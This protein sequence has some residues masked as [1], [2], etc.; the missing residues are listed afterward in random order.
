[1]TRTGVW[2]TPEQRVWSDQ[3]FREER[4]NEP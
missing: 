2:E 1:M 3:G 4:M